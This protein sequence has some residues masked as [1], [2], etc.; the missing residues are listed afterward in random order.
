LDKDLM[1]EKLPDQLA[2]DRRSGQ[3]ENPAP[4][5]RLKR[6]ILGGLSGRLLV[7]TIIF[8]MIAE[9]LIFVP[10]VANFRNVW[11]QN[12]LD[13]AETASIVYLDD[14]ETMLSNKAQED[15]LKA[16]QSLSV[17]IREGSVSRLMASMPTY[18]NVSENINLGIMQPVESLRS[19]LSTLFFG[20]ERTYQVSGPMKSR[21]AEI[22]LVQ[23]DK[24]LRDALLNY[25]RNILLISLVIS[26]ITA[27]LV[28]LTLYWM[29]VR[30]IIR[31]S[32]N[33]DEFSRHP[34]NRALVYN[35]TGRGDELG[36]AEERLSALQSDLQTTLRQKQH[37]AELGLAVSKINHDLRNILASALL[38][39]D[40]LAGI[41]DPTVQRFAPK[42]VKTIER[43]VEYTRSVLA[44]GKAMESAPKLR[45]HQLA[46]IIDEVGESL[47]I[48]HSSGFEWHNG[49][50]AD[51]TVNCDPEQIFRA[52]LNLGRNAVQAMADAPSPA[53]VSR[54]EITASQNSADTRIRVRDTGPGIPDHQKPKLFAAFQSSGKSGG[55]GLGLAIAAELVR[56]HGGTIELEKSDGAGS[57]FLITLPGGAQAG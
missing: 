19:A 31:L 24:Y 47:G 52:V 3:S 37:L 5:A 7:L 27:S 55:T 48:E 43:A 53:S 20:G 40:R 8:V 42:L 51:I 21:Q 46:G 1:L 33:M 14:S 11:L 4:R 12:H 30:P 17:S 16:T 26:L 6:S 44:Y 28:F 54:L 32:S 22:K 36:I 25:A 18:N 35:P 50:D 23:E 49:V 10:S 38:F 45:T 34:E 41:S 39:S 13:T 2:S 9:V 15:L 29:I 56:A 57:V